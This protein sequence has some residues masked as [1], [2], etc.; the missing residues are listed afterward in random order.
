MLD[1]KTS[2][3]F[4][5]AALKDFFTGGRA[6]AGFEAVFARAAALR[7]LVGT[8]SHRGKLY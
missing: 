5:A 4:K 7:G 3:L 1:G 6:E 2:S 8:F